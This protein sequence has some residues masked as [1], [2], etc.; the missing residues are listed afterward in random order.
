VQ[1]LFDGCADRGLELTTVKRSI[2]QALES[3]DANIR[4][5]A[6]CKEEVPLWLASK[7]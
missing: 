5:L 2:S 6:S 3:I 4:W 1:A 7:Q